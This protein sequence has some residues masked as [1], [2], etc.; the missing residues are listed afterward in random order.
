MSS[1]KI[2]IKKLEPIP[3]L[4]VSYT[5]IFKEKKNTM[6]L[7]TKSVKIDNLKNERSVYTPTVVT[8]F[9]FFSELMKHL[10]EYSATNAYRRGDKL[11]VNMSR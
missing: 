4:T 1:I 9:N 6:F 8:L 2:L 11:S 7:D 10:Q 5:F 3:R